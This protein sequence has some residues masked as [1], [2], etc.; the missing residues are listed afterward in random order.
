MASDD[1]RTR[2]EFIGMD[3]RQRETVASMRPMVEA[4]IGAALDR[5]YK[6]AMRT[7]DTRRFFADEAQ[8]QRARASQM[9]HWLRITSGRFDG[10]FTDSVSASGMFMPASGLIHAGTSAPMDWSSKD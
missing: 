1:L 4:T 5:F 2:L 8:M 6:V 10:E 3:A 7:P 9:R